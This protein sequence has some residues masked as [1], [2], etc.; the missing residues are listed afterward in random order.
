[1]D[2]GS[3]GRRRRKED[4]QIAKFRLRS[5]LCVR[6]N[7][8]VGQSYCAAARSDPWHASYHEREY[9]FPIADDSSLLE[10]LTLEINQAGLSWL[11]ILK[12]RE[13]FRRAFEG[14]DPA[15]VAS[16]GAADRRRLLADAGII[17]NRA[18]VAAVIENA[19]RILALRESHG[20]FARWLDAH[21]PRSR[22]RW[23]R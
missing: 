8:G 21:H 1:M 17:R 12:K 10:Q 22:E 14:F 16:Y 9:G 11:T 3:S 15:T 7:R 18:K 2:F 4:E 19:R 23:R 6:E 13:A 20:S 5:R